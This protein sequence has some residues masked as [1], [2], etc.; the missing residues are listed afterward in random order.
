MKDKVVVSDDLSSLFAIVSDTAATIAFTTLVSDAAGAAVLHV[1]GSTSNQLVITITNQTSRE[2]DVTKLAGAPTSSNSNIIL[3]LPNN[4]FYFY[5][6]PTIDAKGSTPGT[7]ELATARLGGGWVDT[8]YLA[9]TGTCTL[10]AKGAADDTL[11]LV[12]NYGVAVPDDPK[13][14]NVTVQVQYRNIQTASGIPLK[15]STPPQTLDLMANAGKPLPLVGEF[16][17]PRTVLNNGTTKRDLTLRL[18][19]TS[20]DPIQFIVPTSGQPTQSYIEVALPVSDTAGDAIWALCVIAACEAI[21]PRLSGSAAMG[22][23]VTASTTTPGV[24]ELRPDFKKVQNIPPAGTL[25]LVLAGVTSALEPGIVQVQVSLKRFAL[26]GTQTFGVALEKTPLVYNNGLGSGMTLSAGSLGSNTGL[27][28]L[29]DSST[30]LINI[31]QSGSGAALLVDSGGCNDQRRTL[32]RQ[33]HAFRSTLG[34]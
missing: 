14:V 18:V 32:G 31:Q 11:K 10:G 24:F 5:T 21:E 33:R 26:Y 12:I 29:G 17:G 25:E 16:V 8:I 3:K 7:W 13:A 2:L 20:L 22:W 19:N 15:G 28:V 23:S 27:T 1:D 34:K 30:E 4:K 6:A 9:N